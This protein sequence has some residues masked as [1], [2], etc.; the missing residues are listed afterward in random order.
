MYASL[1]L[2]EL[3]NP[4]KTMLHKGPPLLAWAHFN[5]SMDKQLQTLW[6]VEWNYL[7]ISNFNGAD[8]EV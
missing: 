7:S 5:P 4:N 8:A 2:N 1:G 3:Y 6:S